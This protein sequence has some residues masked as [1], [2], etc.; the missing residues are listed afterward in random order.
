LCS[1]TGESRVRIRTGSAAD[2][3]AIDNL[4]L[5]GPLAINTGSGPDSVAIERNG[6]ANGPAS[7]VTGPVRIS[8]KR[9]RDTIRLGA[10]GQAGNSVRFQS[11][12]KLRGGRGLDSL[13]AGL[14]SLPNGNGNEF[15]CPPQL[16]G[17]EDRSS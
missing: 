8:T 16:R 15:L 17:I 12:S 5:N 13:D 4:L 10:A 1:V 2:S 3:V 14:N 6:S 11:C 7:T 9:G